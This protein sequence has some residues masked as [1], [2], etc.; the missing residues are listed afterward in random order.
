LN[1]FEEGECGPIYG[2]QF[3]HCGA[4]YMQGKH[5]YDGYGV[6]QVRQVIQSLKEDPFGRRHVI[7]LWNVTDINN[8]ELVLPP[9]H[10]LYIFL[11]SEIDGEKYLSLHMTQRSCDALLGL[12]FNIVSCTLFLLMMAH[13][14]GYKPYKFYHSIADFH[15]YENHFDAVV[16]QISRN[17]CMFPYVSLNCDVK[18]D[19]KDYE[20]SDFTFHDYYHHNLIKADMVV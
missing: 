5:D 19:P 14:T 7:N 6:D 13:Q 20:F 11:V 9:C 8:K 17:P 12:P 18:D 16:K 10:V 2:F 3:R 15:I 1:H 4:L